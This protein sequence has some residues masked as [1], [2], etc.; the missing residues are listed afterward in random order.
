MFRVE[1]QALCGGEKINRKK[2][3]NTRDLG[4][5]RTWGIT[6]EV[7]KSEMCPAGGSWDVRFWRG[8]PPPR[9][10]PPTRATQTVLPSLVSVL[11]N[12]A[13][14]TTSDP[15]AI[16]P[17]TSITSFWRRCTPKASPAAEERNFF[18]FLF[19]FFFPLLGLQHC[20]TSIYG[21]SCHPRNIPCLQ[22]PQSPPRNEVSSWGRREAAPGSRIG[23][24]KV[25][26]RAPLWDL[27]QVPFLIFSSWLTQTNKE[28]SLGHAQFT[29]SPRW[30]SA[31]VFLCKSF[32]LGCYL[33][34]SKG[35]FLC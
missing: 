6:V 22:Q 5:P 35:L 25:P 31:H 2:K 27:T 28:G 21:L 10:T 34:S 32:P 13:L 18:P 9:G 11:Y 30:K 12:Q 29:N 33:M 3:K 4:I 24:C 19:F 26:W 8:S 16:N 7:Y 15:R 1:K 20:S 23:A 14:S 17:A